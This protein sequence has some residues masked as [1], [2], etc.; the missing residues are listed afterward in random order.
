MLNIIINKGDTFMQE[1]TL[2]LKISKKL[3]FIDVFIL[4]KVGLCFKINKLSK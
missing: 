4:L 2:K 3:I 1:S